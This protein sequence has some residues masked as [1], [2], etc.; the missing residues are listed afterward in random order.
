VR[1]ADKIANV[2]DVLHAPPTNWSL[3]WRLA[4]IDWTERV[5]E[6]CRGCHPG[7]EAHFDALV[8]EAREAL[9]GAR[10]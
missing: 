3:D 5:V 8:A 1:I 9:E 2:H 6:G 7:L 4:Y 10:D